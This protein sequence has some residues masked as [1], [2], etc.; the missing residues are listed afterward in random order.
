MRLV[1]ALATLVLSL[2]TASAEP[3]R[4]FY[5][6]GEAV[7][8]GC[9]KSF[10]RWNNGSVAVPAPNPDTRDVYERVDRNRESIEECPSRD[11][12]A[13]AELQRLAEVRGIHVVEVLPILEAHYR[14][15]RRPLDFRPVDPHWNGL[16]TSL[17]ADAISRRLGGSVFDSVF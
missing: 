14:A 4:A 6:L 13:L 15:H 7:P 2:G 10:D 12:L 17:I 11:S 16:A 1:T 8:P 3:C 9:A 5:P